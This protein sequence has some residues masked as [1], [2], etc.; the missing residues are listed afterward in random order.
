MSPKTKPQKTINRRQ[1]FHHCTLFSLY[2]ILLH[3]SLCLVSANNDLLFDEIEERIRDDYR[4][5]TGDSTNPPLANILAWQKQINHV[6]SSPSYKGLV[7]RYLALTGLSPK[8]IRPCQVI[9]WAQQQKRMNAQ[10]V[11][12]LTQQQRLRE[13][14]KSDSLTVMKELSS[15]I[16]TPLDFMAIPFGLS[17]FSVAW[18]VKK[19]KAN[20]TTPTENVLQADSIVIKGIPFTASFIFDSLNRYY[21][22]E[23]QSQSG[24]ADSLNN[25]IRL[26]ADTLAAY[27]EDIL[28]PPTHINRIGLFDIRPGNITLQKIWYTDMVDVVIGFGTKNYVYYAHAI[29]ELRDYLRFQNPP[30]PLMERSDITNTE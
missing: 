30:D 1:Y 22:Y 14:A 19:N 25:V 21:R 20:L 23:L 12:S 18:I 15:S 4:I 27:F 6:I 28:G 3:G 26:H 17:P 13:I 24:P 5:C 2:Y 7:K 11:K 10:I 8:D 29:A 9:R 16:A